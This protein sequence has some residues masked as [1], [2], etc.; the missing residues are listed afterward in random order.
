METFDRM[1]DNQMKM[2]SK[3]LVWLLKP[4]Q[5]ERKRIMITCNESGKAEH[6]DCQSVVTN[7]S[8]KS[9]FLA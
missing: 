2:V 1:K 9:T 5:M 4:D 7:P 8:C 6:F 3:G